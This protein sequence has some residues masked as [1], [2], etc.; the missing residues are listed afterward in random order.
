M[1]VFG[2]SVALRGRSRMSSADVFLSE[3]TFTA[4]SVPVKFSNPRCEV[5]PRVTTPVC[6]YALRKLRVTLDREGTR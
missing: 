6:L 4:C 2:G 3:N 5:G 1:E